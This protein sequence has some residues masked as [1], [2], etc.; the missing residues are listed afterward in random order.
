M[1]TTYYG[2]VTVTF[3][4]ICFQCGET[5]GSEVL[6]NDFTRDV[7]RKYTKVRPICRTCRNTG[8]DPSTWGVTNLKSTYR[9]LNCL[10]I[11][12]DEWK[13]FLSHYF[14]YLQMLF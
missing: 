13:Q 3:K 12:H 8:K 1:E 11:L 2:S 7:K 10:H 5:S 6:N 9:Y 4:L 14:R